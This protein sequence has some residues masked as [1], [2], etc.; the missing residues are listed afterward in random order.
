MSPTNIHNASDLLRHAGY[1]IE[2]QAIIQPFGRQVY[3]DVGAHSQE[4]IN[5]FRKLLNCGIQDQWVSNTGDNFPAFRVVYTAGLINIPKVC[6]SDAFASKFALKDSGHRR[7]E[8]PGEPGNEPKEPL[9]YILIVQRSN[10][11]E[12]SKIITKSTLEGAARAILHE[13]ADGFSVVFSGATFRTNVANMF[14]EYESSGN[15]NFV[16]VTDIAELNATATV[17]DNRRGG[18]V[19]ILC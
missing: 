16:K 7:H 9:C 4:D 18:K 3:I 10:A 6:V 2:D 12:R 5:K 13:A 19:G 8:R 14:P 15:F 17:G 11:S 1:P